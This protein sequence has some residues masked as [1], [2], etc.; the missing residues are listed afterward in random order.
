MI[1]RLD[2]F[3]RILGVTSSHAVP[4]PLNSFSI[5]NNHTSTYGYHS[6]I[7][8]NV[9]INSYY[10]NIS[11]TAGNVLIPA[12]LN[13]Y[14]AC[15]FMDHSSDLT[16]SD[17]NIGNF[18]SK[19]S[20]NKSLVTRLGTMYP[21]RFFR[22]RFKSLSYF[23]SVSNFITGD[24]PSGTSL[25]VFGTIMDNRSSAYSTPLSSSILV[26][27]RINSAGSANGAMRI[28][29][30]Y[31]FYKSKR[32]EIW[33][34]SR[35]SNLCKVSYKYGS[36]ECDNICMITWFL[37]TISDQSSLNFFYISFHSFFYLRKFTS[38][39]L[40]VLY[41]AKNSRIR[42][43]RYRAVACKK[44]KWWYFLYAMYHLQ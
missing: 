7:C 27:I 32:R 14:R 17:D 33:L 1:S 15:D 6:I 20:C 21:M 11:Q 44:S 43:W 40:L 13:T 24:K 9:G 41:L 18:K 36:Q 4:R 31:G 28:T 39:R 35:V 26:Y 37:E 8:Y 34:F 22:V 12:S 10:E 16:I 42:G 29:L 25:W 5:L 38:I 30:V 23:V 3:F 19:D 2:R